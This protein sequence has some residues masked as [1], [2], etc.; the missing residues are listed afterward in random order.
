[1]AKNGRV[2]IA[3]NRTGHMD[4]EV[5][6]NSQLFDALPVGIF[7]VDAEGQCIYVNTYWQELTGLSSAQALGQGWQQSIH[8]LDRDR[9]L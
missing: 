5:S 6:F 4:T 8:D 9:V 2:C 1:M 3:Y 7:V